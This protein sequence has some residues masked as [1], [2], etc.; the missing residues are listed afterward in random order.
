[1]KTT[2]EI[3]YGFKN[4]LQFHDKNSLLNYE[5][6]IKNTDNHNFIVPWQ[7]VEKTKKEVLVE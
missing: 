4:K 2:E 1:M 7:M 3:V 5:I 6:R